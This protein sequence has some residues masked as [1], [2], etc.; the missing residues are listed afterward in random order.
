MNPQVLQRF[1]KYMFVFILVVGA[2]YILL[3][4]PLGRAPGDYYT[5]V[6]GN[7]LR[8]SDWKGAMEAFD[9]ALKEAPNHRGAMMGKAIVYIQTK[10]HAKAI[11]EL[12]KLIA[13]LEKTLKAD[14]PT[15]RGTLAAAFAN[16]GIVHDREGR[17]E[18]ALNDY[19]ISLRIDPDSVSGP[20]LFHRIVHGRQST[21]RKRAE[22]IAQQLKLPPEKRLLRVPEV[23]EKQRMHRP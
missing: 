21:I 5:E 13:F 18:L 7:R 12:D 9:K 4:E 6:G 23:D 22:Y 8:D 15:G 16:R 11:A 2:G 19:A 20:D 17:F 10:Q 1:V 14:D 3:Q